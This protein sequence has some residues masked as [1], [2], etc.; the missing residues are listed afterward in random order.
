MSPQHRFFPV[1]GLRVR[2]T[3]LTIV[4]ALVLSSLLPS[5]PSRAQTLDGA[6]SIHAAGY[7][8][9][10]NAPQTVRGILRS[11]PLLGLGF[12][13]IQTNATETVTVLVNLNTLLL[14]GVPPVGSWVRVQGQLQLG[15]TILA[16]WVAPD[17]YEPGQV[18]VRLLWA[19]SAR[20]APPF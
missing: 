8:Q 17:T 14:Q 18:V 19:K 3:Q 15:G 9:T 10:A 16:A 5:D 12:W 20:G 2:V 11:V 6:D 1:H 4:L 13:R 7:E